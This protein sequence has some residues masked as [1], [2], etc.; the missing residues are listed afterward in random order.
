MIIVKL[1]FGI[2]FLYNVVGLTAAVLGEMS[3]LFAA[4]LMPLSSISVVAFTSLST[5]LR[6]RKYFK[7]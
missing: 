7:F 5:W 1:T 6:S 4:I 2:S 3:P